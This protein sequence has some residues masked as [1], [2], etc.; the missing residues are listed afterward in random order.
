MTIIMKEGFE[1]TEEIIKI[2][3]GYDLFVCYIENYTQ[4]KNAEEK[5]YEI[6]NQLKELGVEK[7]K[8]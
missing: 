3:K 5:N 7:I 1:V 4:M 6:M 8:E 2:S